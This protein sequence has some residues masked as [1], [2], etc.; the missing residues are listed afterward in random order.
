[1]GERKERRAAERAYR[2]I[3]ARFMLMLLGA[4]TVL[5]STVLAVLIER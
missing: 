5:V 3:W 4:A 2:A 1:V